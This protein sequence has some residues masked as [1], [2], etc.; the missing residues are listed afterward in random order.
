MAETP[1]DLLSRKLQTLWPDPED[2]ARAAEILAD[3]GRASHE[4]EPG[5]V[6]LAILRLADHDL[7]RLAE[8]RVLAATDYR[9]VLMMAEYPEESAL[10]PVFGRPLTR[11]ERRALR[12]ARARDRRAY[13]VWLAG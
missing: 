7:Q 13:E 4:G 1:D 6:R 3:Y 2:R 12:D 10:P 8:V 9:D 5:R 11:D